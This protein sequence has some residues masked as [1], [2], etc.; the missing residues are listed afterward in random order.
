ML[1]LL[2]SPASVISAAGTI[3]SE[4]ISVLA[5]IAKTN[6]VGIVSNKE[7]PQWLSAAVEGT[8]IQVVKVQ[9]RQSGA[10]IKQLAK[11][12]DV[13]TYNILCLTAS[14]VDYQMG[15]NG[16]AILVAAGW[17]ADA[18]AKSLG[19][20]VDN[21]KELLEV[22]TLSS[23]WNGSW[24]YSGDGK[25]YNVRALADL[26][27]YGPQID[28]A[29]FSRKVT[30]AVK[31][32]GGPLNALLTIT[33]RSLLLEWGGERKGVLF[34][35]YP[36]SDPKNYNNEV[37][38]DFTHRL[39]TTVSRVHHADRKEPLFIRHLR[40][41]KRSAGQ[42][43]NRLD[44]QNQVTTIHLNPYYKQSIVGKDVIL[45]DDCTTYGLSFG[46]AA[47]FLYKAGAKSMTGIALG[48]FG[49]RLESF[50]VSIENDPFNKVWPAQYTLYEHV[51]FPGTAEQNAQRDLK[52]LIP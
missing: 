14:D 32:G 19:I 35:V 11:K 29:A 34:G 10:F 21:A 42:G 20:K 22:F 25:H 40:A 18:K 48:K 8:K 45:I 6:P 28:Q 33:A 15:K 37:L 47:G 17:A 36:S 1:I 39:R 49:G 51:A 30:D 23:E 27:S 9:G 26:S 3:N 13:P 41:P 24:W 44:P 52:N 46:V 16:G 43:G 7:A 5:E 12:A 50:S 2:A 31:K 4:I 38:T